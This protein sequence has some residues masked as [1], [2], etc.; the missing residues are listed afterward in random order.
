[1]SAV[2][3]FVGLTVIIAAVTKWVD[4]LVN[5]DWDNWK[6]DEDDGWP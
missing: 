4:L 1:M 2:L 6:D 3:S 5:C